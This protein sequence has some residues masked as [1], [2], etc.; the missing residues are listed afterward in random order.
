MYNTEIIIEKLCKIRDL[1]FFGVIIETL[2][3]SILIISHL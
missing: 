3:S 1:L 2:L